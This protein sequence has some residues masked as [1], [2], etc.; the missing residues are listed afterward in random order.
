MLDFTEDLKIQIG[1]RCPVFEELLIG[2]ASNLSFTPPSNTFGSRF[3]SRPSTLS[4]SVDTEIVYGQG[5][6]TEYT[7]KKGG[8]HE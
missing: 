4:N 8:S 2:A 7:A 3:L 6:G 5:A 1:V